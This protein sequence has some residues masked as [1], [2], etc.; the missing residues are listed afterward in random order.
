MPSYVNRHVLYHKHRTT[1]DFSSTSV[2]HPY[3]CDD[4]DEQYVKRWSLGVH[5]R[6]VLAM[7]PSDQAF[8]VIQ[9]RYG[10]K[11][12]EH[13]EVIRNVVVWLIHYFLVGR[14][15]SAPKSQQ[16]KRREL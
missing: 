1:A 4:V 6:K 10:F 7:P 12:C 8:D 15:T 16:V 3:F 9:H 13:L 11:H 14:I 5:N 2:Y